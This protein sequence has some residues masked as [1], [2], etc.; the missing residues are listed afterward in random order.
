MNSEIHKNNSANA[1]HGPRLVH[2]MCRD[3]AEMTSDH[4]GPGPGPVLTV[5]LMVCVVGDRCN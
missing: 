1:L 2:K 3:R 5:A 4:I